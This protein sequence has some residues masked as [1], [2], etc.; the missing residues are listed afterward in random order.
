MVDGRR[1]TPILMYLQR[2][3]DVM[4]SARPA[5]DARSRS[6]RRGGR[7]GERRG[8]RRGLLAAIKYLSHTPAAALLT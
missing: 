3:I 1:D 6:E 2:G 8:E 4:D 7:R 5:R